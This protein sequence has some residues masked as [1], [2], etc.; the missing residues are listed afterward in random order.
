MQASAEGFHSAQQGVGATFEGINLIAGKRTPFGKFCGALSSVSPTDLGILASRA[1]LDAC[2]IEGGEIDQTIVANVGQASSDTFFLPRHIA[3]YSGARQASPA[4]LVQ[5]ICGSGIE[6]IG[7][8]AEQI[9]LG[10]ARLVLGCGTETMSRFPLVS[11]GARQGFGLGR[12]EF[13]DL[14]WEALDDTAAVPMGRTADILA[15]RFELQREQVD[16]F[17]LRSQQRYAQA[18]EAGFF[19]GELALVESRGTFEADGIKPRRYRLQTREALSADEH[20]RMT[21]LER[22]AR[23]PPV[24]SETGPTT[25]G[26]ASG[27][28]DGACSV[29]LAADE[30]LAANGLAALGKIRS[31]AAVGVEPEIMGI[32]PVPAIRAVLEASGLELGD[33]DLFEINEAFGAQCLAVARELKLD[34]ERLNVH[35]GAIAIGHPL[36]ATGCRLVTT[37]LKALET[38]DARFGIAAACIG[39][40]QGIAMLLERA[41]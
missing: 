4:L 1:V 9:C 31:I 30:Y 22:L 26:S 28:V 33:I 14:L 21:D 16:Q 24:F 6:L 34:Q 20:P 35:G 27:I 19:A 3:L 18:A 5:R 41:G 17:A 10:K 37:C 12:P 32:G 23:L 13:T 8:A 15:K 11:Y 2:S 38:R 40:G 39:G 7:A 36:A 29:L 25:A